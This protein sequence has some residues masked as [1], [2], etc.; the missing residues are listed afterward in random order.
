MWHI[1]VLD[2]IVNG[3]A[4]EKP[5]VPKWTADLIVKHLVV[6]WFTVFEEFD[7]YNESPWEV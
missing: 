3:N 2:S 6:D 5:T 1:Y 7:M 4:L